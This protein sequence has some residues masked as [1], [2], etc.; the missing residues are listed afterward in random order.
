MNPVLQ[1]FGLLLSAAAALVGALVLWNLRTLCKRLDAVD[2][3]MNKLEGEQKLLA[4]RKENCQRDFVSSE[5]WI[6]SE[7][8][9]RQKLDKIA[10]SV[11]TLAG[12]LKVVEQMPQICGQIAR[13]IIREMKAGK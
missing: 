8:Y 12:S 2:R 3:R 13:D 5:A 11:A 6:R 1:V 10:E 9:T 4:G 7:T